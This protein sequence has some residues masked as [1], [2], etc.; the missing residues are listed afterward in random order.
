MWSVLALDQSMTATGWAHMAQGQSLP[1]WGKFTSPN[2]K[3]IEGERGVEFYEWIGVKC[4]DLAVTQIVFEM[5]FDP[6]RYRSDFTEQAAR[7]GMPL[8]VDMVRYLC[9]AKRG[10]QIE[11]SPVNASQW[12]ASFLG[13][14]SAP[15]GLVESQRRTWYKERAVAECHSRGWMIDSNDIA[16]AL[17]ILDY[18]CAAIDPAYA[19]TRGALFRRAEAFC[20]NEQRS[21]K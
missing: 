11:C 21:L 5:P 2:W 4:V 6:P 20:E 9:N 16:D 14:S 12:R 7:W 13:S 1:T 19:S 15:K 17:G 3:G 10:M 8:L 18:S